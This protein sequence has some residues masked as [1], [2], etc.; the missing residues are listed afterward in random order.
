[1][2]WLKEEHDLEQMSDDE[3]EPESDLDKSENESDEDS[4]QSTEDGSI[5]DKF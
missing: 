1:M 2:Q 5:S 3:P 4:A